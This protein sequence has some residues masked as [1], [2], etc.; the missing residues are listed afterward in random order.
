M[1][2]IIKTMRKDVP[3]SLSAALWSPPFDVWC[4]IH[5]QL[6]TTKQFSFKYMY[7]VY[8]IQ[9]IIPHDHLPHTSQGREFLFLI[10]SDL[11]WDSSKENVWAKYMYIFLNMFHNQTILTSPCSSGGGGGCPVM[12]VVP[13]TWTMFCECVLW[14]EDVLSSVSLEYRL[15]CVT[16]CHI[17][18]KR[19]GPK[20]IAETTCSSD[21]DMYITW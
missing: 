20:N 15:C 14:S 2:R 4:R 13:L 8:Q 12:T 21:I 9:F 5:L 10:F 7:Q 6:Q 3:L 11:S 18:S 19:S 17:Y 1:K 16:F